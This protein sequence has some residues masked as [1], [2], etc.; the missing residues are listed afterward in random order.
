MTDFVNATGTLDP[1]ADAVRVELEVARP[2]C[3]SR[4]APVRV[5]ASRLVYVRG[6]GRASTPRSNA[7]LLKSLLWVLLASF[8]RWFRAGVWSPK[9][10]H[11]ITR[12]ETRIHVRRDQAH[13][14]TDSHTAH[15]WI[16]VSRLTTRRPLL[17]QLDL[18]DALSPPREPGRESQMLEQRPS[19]GPRPRSF[20]PHL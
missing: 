12:R 19:K 15:R 10:G 11:T 14:V 13:T 1:T 3:S 6:G 7:G 5:R 4:Y 8:G 2:P 20:S 17:S 18:S 9:P 16:R